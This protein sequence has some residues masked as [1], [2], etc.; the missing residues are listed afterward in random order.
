MVR[1]QDKFYQG[2]TLNRAW[3]EIP[4]SA[5]AEMLDTV[6]TKVLQFA[7]E[8]EGKAADIDE[9]IQKGEV[10][11]LSPTV[12]HVFNTVIF[13]GS[14]VVGAQAGHTINVAERQI[15]IEGDYN[16]LTSRLEAEGV[17]SEKI[18]ELR[19]LMS[20]DE[21]SAKAEQTLTDRLK[22]WVADAAGSAAKAG[23][24][25][26]IEVTKA[27]LTAAIKSYLGLPSA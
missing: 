25:A 19:H 21:T 9:A 2:Y 27:V 15:I 8:L 12:S 23:G 26:T 22:R 17:S 18:D 3:Q 4:I 1:Y 5:I 16:S 24:T 11:S 20:S 14:A 7:L 13:G 10:Q 6:K